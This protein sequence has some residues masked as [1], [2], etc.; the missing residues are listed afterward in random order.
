M[1]KILWRVSVIT[2]KR[3]DAKTLETVVKEDTKKWMNRSMYLG[4]FKIGEQELS[5][6]CYMIIYLNKRLW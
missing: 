5:S 4:Y 6:S 1:S 2:I 3:K